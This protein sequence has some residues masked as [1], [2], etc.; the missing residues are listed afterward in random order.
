M[1]Q[2]GCSSRA[3]GLEADQVQLLVC[4]SMNHP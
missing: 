3:A 4:Q 2:A 1:A